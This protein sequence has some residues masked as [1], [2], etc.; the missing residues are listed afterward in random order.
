MVKSRTD[1]VDEQTTSANVWRDIRITATGK[2]VGREHKT[3]D[4]HRHG[5][6]EKIILK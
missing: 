1:E 6:G 2:H 5:G 3:C 4:T